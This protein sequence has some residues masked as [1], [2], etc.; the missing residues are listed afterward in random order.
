VCVWQRILIKVIYLNIMI[1]T[2]STY[3]LFFWNF[4]F[5]R[6]CLTN[7]MELSLSW[8]ANSHSG[9]QEIPCLLWNPKIHYHDDKSLP[10]IP[11]L[12]QMLSNSEALCN[13]S[14]QAGLLWWGVVCPT[15]KLED[16]PLSSFYDCLCNIFTA[17]SISGGC[18]FHPHT[19]DML[20]P[21][22]VTGTHI[23]GLSLTLN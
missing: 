20:M 4:N 13:I 17:T 9:S 8:E 18:L 22:M 10:L 23:T 1:T 14:W 12:N 6:L 3:S 19:E 2:V 16:H 11:I 5:G 7:S 21:S 15:P